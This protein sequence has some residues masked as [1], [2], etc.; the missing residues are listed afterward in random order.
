MWTLTS[1]DYEQHFRVCDRSDCFSA[2]CAMRIC[3]SLKLT[4]KKQTGKTGFANSYRN[5]LGCSANS[6]LIRHCV[7]SDESMWNYRGGGRI[8]PG[9]FRCIPNEGRAAQLHQGICLWLNWDHPLCKVINTGL[10]SYCIT[11]ATQRWHSIFA[12]RQ[13]MEILD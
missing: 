2:V 3:A 9:H 4:E 5:P 1:P 8:Y 6:P 11:C 10:E 13:T 7:L 12:L